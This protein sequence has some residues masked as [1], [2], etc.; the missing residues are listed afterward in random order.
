[1]QRRDTIVTALIWSCALHLLVGLAAH[2][3]WLVPAPRIEAAASTTMNLSLL[4]ASTPV[5]TAPPKPSSH[6]EAAPAHSQPD[7]YPA[8]PQQPADVAAAVPPPVNLNPAPLLTEPFELQIA[9]L[10]F[11]Q[12][13]APRQRRALETALNQVSPTLPPWTDG[14]APRRWRDG[15]HEYILERQPPASA[16]SLE[17]AVLRVT[18]IENGLALEAE[19][20]VTRMA[21]SHFA[22]VVDRWNPEVDLAGDRVI[23]RFH[24]NSALYVSAV[25]GAAPSITGPTT[26]AGRVIIEGRG[27]RAEIFTSGLETHAR[28]M[29]LPRQPIDP[30][31]F[32]DGDRLHRVRESGRL[33]FL[34][35]GGY[36][37][38]PANDTTATLHI[39]PSGY[40]WLVQAEKGVELQVQGE[41]QGSLLVYSPERISITGSLRYAHDPRRGPS[42]DFL[43]LVSDANVEIATPEITGPGDLDVQAAIFAGGQFRVRHYNNRNGGLLRVL[44]SVTAGTL[45]ATEPRFKTAL[46]FDQRLEEQRPAHFPMT[47]RYQVDEGELLWT[48][49]SSPGSD[50]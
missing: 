46:E 24:A 23:G 40:P 29:L 30:T 39:L 16:T 18:K 12:P 8:A 26:V 1:M 49:A 28:R 41:V 4:P 32:S 13:M 35:D 6:S 43:G 10:V 20:P 37:W 42:T 11:K 14:S 34:A 5:N 44:G 9:T 48:V 19:V 21:F 3:W 36:L 25:A 22:Q 45:S 15:E 31:A 17:R 33:V 38:Q 7:A 50:P 27:R 47:D 2:R